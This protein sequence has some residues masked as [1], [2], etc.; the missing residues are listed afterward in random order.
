MIGN[1]VGVLA[2]VVAALALLPS[3]DAPQAQA[4]PATGQN[5]THSIKITLADITLAGK[6]DC[7]VI[8]VSP[9]TVGI[10]LGDWVVWNVDNACATDATVRLEMDPVAGTKPIELKADSKLFVN[11]QTWRGEVSS[12]PRQ[13]RAHLVTQVDDKEW[14]SGKP[15]QPICIPGTSFCVRLCQCGRP[16]CPPPTP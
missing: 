6:T 7:R 5:T 3:S 11:G 10:Y 14:T 13:G 15:C 16:P 9:E 12:V 8:S 1:R 4:P 2:T